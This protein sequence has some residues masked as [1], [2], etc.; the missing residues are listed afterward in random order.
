MK[1]LMVIVTVVI[2]GLV[3]SPVWASANNNLVAGGAGDATTNATW[4]IRN[5]SG[6]LVSTGSLAT[7]RTGH[8]GAR[9]STGNIILVGGIINPTTWEIRNTSGALVSSGSL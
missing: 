7:A 9:F 4:E 2:A 6:G 3:L 8:C 1:R 5:S